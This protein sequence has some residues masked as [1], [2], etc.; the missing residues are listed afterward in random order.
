MSIKEALQIVINEAMS[1]A[2]GEKNKKVFEAL[3]IVQE[4]AE[5]L[6]E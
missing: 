3:Q 1:S 2:L 5:K 4:Q 6:E